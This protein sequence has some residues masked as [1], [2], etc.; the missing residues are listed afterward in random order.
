MRI[1]NVLQTIP[2]FP[3]IV[4]TLN[5]YMHVRFSKFITN[6]PARKERDCH[7]QEMAHSKNKKKNVIDG[8]GGLTNII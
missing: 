5:E 2:I 1:A 4:Q 6:P 7:D 8:V 3:C